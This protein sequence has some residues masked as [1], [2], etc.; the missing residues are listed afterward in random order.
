MNTEVRDTILIG[1][2]VELKFKSKILKGE[3]FQFLQPNNPIIEG[4]ELISPPI[5][6]T[7]TQGPNELELESRLIITSFDSGSYKLPPFR[8]LRL[9]SDGSVDTL[10]FEAG[11]LEV[12]TIQ[13]DTTSYIPFDV[14]GQL[15]Y[16]FK[17]SE[18]IPW[19]ALLLALFVLIFLIK[20]LLKRLKERKGLFKKQ[21]VNDPPHIK[22][23]KTLEELRS[24]KTWTKDQKLYFTQ[25]SDVLREYLESRY[26]FTAMEMTTNQIVKELRTKDI[27][28][29]MLEKIS[30]LFA[31]SD[32]VKFA[33]FAATL[34]E[35]EEGIPTA[36]KFVND[37]YMSQL[38]E[39]E[40]NVKIDKEGE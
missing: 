18:L 32:L 14:K 25:L 29:A 22:A 6:D 40:S 15:T 3:K 35:C 31:L 21:I 2:H 19:G 8:A 23:L 10:Y 27:D 33:K 4:V 11:D 30:D 20:R 9:K 7:I 36:V 24:Q 38:K 12:T 28:G 17:I 37:S 5:T 1:D 13:I 39:S 16:P 34:S 26:S